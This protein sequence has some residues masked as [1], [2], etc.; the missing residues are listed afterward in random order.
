MMGFAKNALPILVAFNYHT[1]S[2]SLG[3]EMEYGKL[4]IK[5]RILRRD[6][7]GY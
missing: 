7:T 6:H 1:V 2:A 4:C 5:Y 3:G